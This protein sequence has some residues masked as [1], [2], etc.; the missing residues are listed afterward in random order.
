[1]LTCDNVHGCGSTFA[2]NCASHFAGGV[3]TV[4]LRVNRV[5]GESKM[6]QSA[7]AEPR[8]DNPMRASLVTLR[9][10]L[11]SEIEALKKLLST[12][13]SD[14]QGKKVWVGKAAD[15]WAKQLHHNRTRLHTLLNQ[16]VPAVE[17][18]ISKCPEK[19]SPGTAKMMQMNLGNP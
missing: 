18:E 10:S 1:M 13:D 11:K 6:T 12:T 8:V 7:S 15:D 3:A 2:Y 17:A 14:M 9:N 4:E 5:E 19:V 16:L